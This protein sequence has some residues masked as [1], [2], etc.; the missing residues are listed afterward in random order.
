MASVRFGLF[1]RQ[2]LLGTYTSLTSAVAASLRVDA[3]I[4]FS[5]QLAPPI[6]GVTAEFFTVEWRGMI[7]SQHSQV[8]QTGLC[9]FCNHGP[10]SD[11][12][13]CAVPQARWIVQMHTLML[14]SSSVSCARL[15]VAGQ[16]VFDTWSMP[17]PSCCTKALLCMHSDRGWCGRFLCSR[18]AWCCHVTCTQACVASA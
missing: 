13:S 9:C 3:A 15:H 2:G 14:S 10:S 11:G 18:E 5:W 1:C 7:V 4:D 17:Q 6:D 16:L 8:S 12:F